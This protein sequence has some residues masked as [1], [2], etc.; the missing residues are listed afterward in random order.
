MANASEVRVSRLFV[1]LNPAAG[2]YS[3]RK[4]HE[5]LERHLKCAGGTCDVHEATG[6]EDLT[7]LARAA[8]ER[9]WEIVVAGGG[10]G[11]VSGV[12]NGLVGTDATLGIL[13][14]GT[15]NI[16]AQE[17]GIPL[18][19]EGAC[20]LLSGPHAVARIDAMEVE[21][22]HSYMRV[23]IGVD[24]LVI[25]DTNREAKRRFGW[26]AYAWAAFT[27][28]IGFQPRQFR[29]TV[30]GRPSDH[31]ASEVAL[32]NCGIMG[33]HP[34]RWGPGIRPDDGR[35]N[36]CI[37]RARDL[38][39]YLV[40]AWHLVLGRPRPNRRM[41]YLVAERTIAVAADIPLIVQADGETIGETPV[42]VNVVPGD[43][44]VVVPEGGIP[45]PPV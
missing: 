11:T 16:V 9:G 39:D 45:P 43:M 15:G 30:D 13:P 14:L 44:R 41:T 37:I 35:I 23:G 3:S 24:A 20:A 25:R 26:V 27:R 1:I 29:I 42:E 34:L 17:L 22:R 12:A 8:A 7:E 40:V 38:I 18:D 5:A 2:S 10:D 28:L 19:L 33:R 4:V 21:G 32:A 36:V 31:R 6:H